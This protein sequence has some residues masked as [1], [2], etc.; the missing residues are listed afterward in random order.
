[1]M[2]KPEEQDEIYQLGISPLTRILMFI[3]FLPATISFISITVALTMFPPDFKDIWLRYSARLCF[4]TLTGA[5]AM[6]CGAGFLASVLPKPKCH[7]VTFWMAK[8]IGKCILWIFIFSVLVSSYF[9]IR[10]NFNI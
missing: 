6:M 10:K 1:M 9:I 5:A 7:H 2:N 4:T 8:K 3:I